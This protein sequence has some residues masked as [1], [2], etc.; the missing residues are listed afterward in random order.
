MLS[1]KDVSRKAGV[2]PMT[3]SRVIRNLPS[4]R[5]STR[6]RVLKVIEEMDYAP[7]LSARGLVTG[8]TQLLTLVTPPDPG[9]LGAYCFTEFLRGISSALSGSGYRLLIYQ[10]DCDASWGYEPRLNGFQSDG[11]LL[12]SPPMDDRFVKYLEVKKKPAVL[13]TSRSSSL[14]WVDLDN[15]RASLGVV[16]KLAALGCRR[17]AFIDGSCRADRVCQDRLDG[18]RQALGKLQIPFDADLVVKGNF[19]MDGGYESAKKLLA[20]PRPPTAIFAINDITAMGAIKAVAEAGLRVPND[21]AVVGF[22]DVDMAAVMVPS[23]STVKQPFF[24]MGKTACQFLIAR[25]ENPQGRQQF[26]EFPGEIIL[27]QTAPGD[28]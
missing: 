24:H 25:I 15:V 6:E 2:S 20:L 1:L 11:V 5:P 26:Q 19:K 22:D 21:V 28:R 23:L 18:Y 4:V 16:E 14:D 9:Y 12:I 3:V 27:R 10:P 13:I 8:K 7:N 17:I